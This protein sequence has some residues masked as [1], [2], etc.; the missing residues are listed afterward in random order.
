MRSERSLTQQA[1]SA[2]RT[3]LI[4]CGLS[5]LLLRLGLLGLEETRRRLALRH[6]P[7]GAHGLEIGALHCPLPLPPG[8]QARYVDRHTPQTLRQLRADAGALIVTPDLLADGFELGCIAAASQDF[9]IANHVL[10]HAA[11]AL[12]TLANWLRVL[13]PGGI[14]F[15]A[16]PRGERCFD[17]GR[18]VTP[19]AHFLDDSRLSAA[20]M[21]EAMRER[22]RAHVEEHLAISAP[23]LARE[24]GVP[25]APPQGVERERLVE[26]LLGR[27]AGQ[28]HHHVFTQDSFTA[29]LALLGEQVRIERL[30][31]SSVEIVA[32]VRKRT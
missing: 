21:H 26:R 2:L 14:L 3:A 30:A 18:A 22:N 20:G 25:W 7:S 16:V 32:I 5:G 9:V 10:E 11:D 1:W 28:I 17:R 15:V 23:A 13:R 29:L 8:A 6:L 27:D 24:Q 4:G 31:R 12:G 19:V